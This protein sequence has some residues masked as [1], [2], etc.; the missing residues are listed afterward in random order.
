ML[1]NRVGVLH[2]GRLIQVGPSLE[3]FTR[4][5]DVE[6]AEI[7]GT[8]NRI[9]EIIEANTGTVAKVRFDGGVAE[10]IGNFEPGAQVVL[11]IRPE[12]IMLSRP[13]NEPRSSGALNNLKAR[14][15]TF[16][17]WALHYRLA[18]Q[19]GGNRLVAL[20]TRTSF[21]DLDVREEDELSACF[22]A[23]AVHVIRAQ[24][25]GPQP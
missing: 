10:V 11:C 16:I 12:D 22:S 2:G 17:P 1:G 13:G 21:L 24:A 15:L 4:P 23:A 9:R 5:L 7:I 8:D 6:V 19:C 3:V 20:I 14:V 25:N 18:L